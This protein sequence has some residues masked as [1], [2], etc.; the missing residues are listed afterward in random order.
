MWPRGRY[1]QAKREKEPCYTMEDER[2]LP[3][4]REFVIQVHVGDHVTQGV[5]PSK[6]LA[7]R[8]AAE[9]MLQLL[10]YSR[11]TPQPVKPAI[12]TGGEVREGIPLK[13]SP[14]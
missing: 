2:G 11:P 13:N 12:K 4:H 14:F 9:A 10:G 1:L 3:R 5:G 6:K 7:K 8:S